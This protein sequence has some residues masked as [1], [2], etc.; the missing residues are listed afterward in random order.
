MILVIDIKQHAMQP[1]RIYNVK[2]PSTIANIS[3][4]IKMQ[5]YNYFLAI[6]KK[7]II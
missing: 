4:A 2:I 3:I 1:F 5:E 7:I 6:P